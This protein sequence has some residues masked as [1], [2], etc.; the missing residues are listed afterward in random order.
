LAPISWVSC[1][2]LSSLPNRQ[3]FFPEQSPNGMAFPHPQSGQDEQRY[4]HISSRGG[5]IGDLFKWT[6]DISDDRNAQDEMR[7]A[8]NRAFGALGHGFAPNCPPPPNRRPRRK[9]A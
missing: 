7:P 2:S 6:I 8:K 4:E 1:R 9:A 3:R 5:V